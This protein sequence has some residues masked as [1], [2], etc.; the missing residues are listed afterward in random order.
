MSGTFQLS[1]NGETTPLINAAA[2]AE[3]LRSALETLD[4]I[5]TTAVRA[6]V[7][8]RFPSG[9]SRSNR[10]HIQ[11]TFLASAAQKR[12][13]FRYSGPMV[14]VVY[15]MHGQRK[16]AFRAGNAGTRVHTVNYAW[17]LT[18]D[19]LKLFVSNLAEGV[20]HELFPSFAHMCVPHSLWHIVVETMSG[21]QAA[22]ALSVQEKHR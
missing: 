6:L 4:S 14:A 9:T 11:K 7:C 13:E 20:C 16:H 15:G 10:T 8:F 12:T 18:A 21:R 17:E 2:S 22:R 3:E 1:F 19:R 5:T